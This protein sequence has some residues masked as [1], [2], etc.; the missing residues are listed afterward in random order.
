M[1]KLFTVNVKTNIPSCD[2]KCEN[3]S[4]ETLDIDVYSEEKV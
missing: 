4:F 3:V 1:R 2:C